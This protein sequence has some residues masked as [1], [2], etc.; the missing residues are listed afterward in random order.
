MSLL[1]LEQITDT[2]TSQEEIGKVLQEH[3]RT[4]WDTLKKEHESGLDSLEVIS[5]LTRLM[6]ELVGFV[7]HHAE[8]ELGREGLKRDE[9]LVLMALG[10][11]GRRELAPHSDIDLL[12]LLPDKITPWAEEFT[13]K[14]LYILWDTGIDVGY[15]SRSLADCVSLAVENYDVLTSLLDARFLQGNLD[16]YQKFGEEFRRKTLSRIGEDFV[17][18]KLE[19]M[20]KRLEK[21]G[22]TVYV[23]EPNL[24]EGMGGLRDIHMTLWV[25]KVLYGVD[26]I[27]D[28]EE[29]DLVDRR[30]LRLLKKSLN[31]LLKVRCELH[32][33]ANTARDMLSMERQPYL[34]RRFGFR[35]RGGVPA[36]EQFMQRY[37][38]HAGQVHQITENI[39][40]KCRD[41]ERR[42]PRILLKLKE[43]DL[44]NSFYS[45]DGA[46][47][48]HKPAVEFFRK[49]PGLIMEAF[50]LYQTAG[51]DFSP[52][53]S[54][55]VRR[56]LRYV[57]EAFRSD[58]RIRERFFSI[59]DEDTRLYETLLLMNELRFLGNFI[60]EFSGIH[61]KMQHDYYHTYTVDEHSIRAVRELVDLASSKE[62]DLEIYKSVY[63]ELKDSRQLLLLV[64]LL[65]DIGKGE[66]SGHSEKGAVMAVKVFTRLGLQDDE[67]DTV[68]FLVR[69]HLVMAHI[70]QRRDL[71]EEKTIK[72]F[73]K[74]VETSERLGLLC[75]LTMA[76]LRAVGPGV[77]NEWKGSLIAELFIETSRVLETG[78]LKLEDIASRIERTRS[79]VERNLEKELPADDIRIELNRLTERA[80]LVFRPRKI[81]RLISMRVRMGD[82]DIISEWHQP[83]RGGYTEFYVVANDHPG[84]FAQVTG[85]LAANNVNILG[86]QILTRDDGTVFD[87]LQVT[88]SVMQPI[89][90]SVKFRMVSRELKKTIDGDLTVEDL[91]HTR[92]PSLP[93]EKKK[94]VAGEIIT[95]TRVE[96]S[97]DISDNFTVIDIYTTDRIG[98]LYSITSTFSSLDLSIH[99]A[100]VSTKVDQ[101][102]DVFYV[103]DLK[104][105]KITGKGRMEKIKSKLAEGLGG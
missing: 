18:S 102:V 19:G 2:G 28:L 46:I 64:T 11:Y 86:A 26:R 61:C 105:K 62:S 22:G 23:L 103:T 56:S 100:K 77:W 34:A 98:L 54:V 39:I 78:G 5:Q 20:L 30:D 33:T 73:A 4:A 53:I 91:I 68:D 21:H 57:D 90:D 9:R 29:L 70:A 79:K 42:T 74:L 47:Y 41:S 69:N 85:V 72:E 87:I 13:Q 52:E 104:G 44:G 6:D 59:L 76:D 1:S 89:H 50:R 35:D 7:Y 40:R 31:F 82:D 81:T 43:K 88:D 3:Y 15:S 45:R 99:T 32:F 58:E 97:N 16:L 36:V 55:A 8:S 49:D 75:M 17:K 37:Y 60:P 51:L 80:Y 83:R 14:I 95:P 71:H 63:E 65:H 93:L 94:T 38:S 48:T 67:L 10:S 84:L 96:V 24:K 12:F 101:A 92:K 66:G 27:E 25:A